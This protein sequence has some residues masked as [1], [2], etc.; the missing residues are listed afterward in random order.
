VFR[1]GLLQVVFING[2]ATVLLLTLAGPM[3]RLLF[4]RGE[5]TTESTAR[6]TYALLC[7]AP[8]LVAFSVNNLIARAFYALGDTQTPMRVSMFC[9]AANLLMALILIPLFKQGG[10]GLAN[11]L[12]AGLNSALLFYALRRKLPKLGFRDLAG[13]FAGV[14][15]AA[16]A[17]AAVAWF[18][19]RGLETRM[20]ATSLLA[21][22]GTVFGPIG[23][24]TLIYFAL[25]LWLKLPQAHDF[26]EL[27]RAKLGRRPPA[28]PGSPQPP[29]SP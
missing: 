24:A 5:F 11:T 23:A 7:L 28:D 10:M 14:A 8:G 13:N 6:T 25:A 29:V 2:L 15:G 18:S 22:G 26:L 1:E 19:A 3:I 16:L 4:E 9:L 27:I 21:K 20:G 12:S 17:A